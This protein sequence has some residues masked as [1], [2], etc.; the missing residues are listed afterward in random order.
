MNVINL[1]LFI[2]IFFKIS[3]AFDFAGLLL[4]LELKIP[5]FGTFSDIGMPSQ[6]TLNEYY[7]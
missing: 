4:F 7:L 3:P 5:R 2:L 1:M 6:R